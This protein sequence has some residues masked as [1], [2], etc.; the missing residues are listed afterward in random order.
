MSAAD[1]EDGNRSLRQV[2]AESPFNGNGTPGRLHVFKTQ[3]PVLH[4]VPNACSAPYERAKADFENKPW[5]VRWPAR[6][7]GP[8]G[9]GYTPEMN[10]A[11]LFRRECEKWPGAIPKSM[12]DERQ[13]Q[14]NDFLTGKTPLSPAESLKLRRDM[15]LMNA[16]YNPSVTGTS[17]TS[18]LTG[19]EQA[20]LDNQQLTWGNTMS[21]GFLGP[22]AGPGMATRAMGFDEQ[23]VAGVNTFV[24]SVSDGAAVRFPAKNTLPGQR[25]TQREEGLAQRSRSP[26]QQE[27]L[28]GAVP[29][30]RAGTVVQ[31]APPKLPTK[32]VGDQS[33]PRAGLG[34]SGKKHTSGPLAP[35]NG[36]TGDFQKDLDTLTGGTRPWQAGDSAPPGSLVGSNGIFGRPSNSSGGSSIDIPAN[37]SKPHET[38]HY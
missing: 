5:Y 9:S 23:A 33:D 27:P 15:D 16:V 24:K 1:P 11:M 30:A 2:L 14:L 26:Y 38:L 21:F 4:K 25:A 28:K 29:A 34:K 8:V 36:G 35:E 6:T 12:L 17:L 10:S 3:G 19:A 18:P 31:R 22:F 37:G 32:L 13:Q 20:W 7:Q